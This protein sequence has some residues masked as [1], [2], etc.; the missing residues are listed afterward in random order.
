MYTPYP[1]VTTGNVQTTLDS[2]PKNTLGCVWSPPPSANQ[3]F[4]TTAGSSTPGFGAQP[5]FKYVYYNSTTNPTPVAAPAPVYYTDESFTQVSGN[6]AEAYFTTMGACVAGYLMP[7]TTAIS[8]LTAAQ[9]NQSYCW[10]QVAGFLAGAYAPTTSTNPGQGSSILG[11]TTGNWA[12][13]VINTAT[14]Q[15]VL[16]LQWTAIANNA[17]DILIAGDTTFWGS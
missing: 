5:V 3:V 9:L 13:Q 6:A 12:S 4:S 1:R 16:A 11:L 15:K 8:G 14:A 2:S 7:N 10:I 17:C